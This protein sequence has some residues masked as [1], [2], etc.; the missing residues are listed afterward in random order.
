MMVPGDDDDWKKI[1]GRTTSDIMSVS[2]QMPFKELV[3]LTI[4]QLPF[5]A[6]VY[7]SLKGT[8]SKLKSWSVQKLPFFLLSNAVSFF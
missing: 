2:F 8:S 6:V 1:R 3:D 5:N 7:F 4:D